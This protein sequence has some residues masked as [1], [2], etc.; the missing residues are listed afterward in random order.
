MLK[1]K[2]VLFVDD[3]VSVLST[4]KRMF[5]NEEYEVLTASSGT[6]GLEILAQ[7]EVDLV[8]SDQRMP[9][10]TGAEFLQQVSHKH[11]NTIRMI[12][13]GY[14]DIDAV[15][16][17]VNKGNISRFLT[18]PWDKDNL[19]QI[20]HHWLS[21]VLY[22]A[23]AQCGNKKRCQQLQHVIFEQEEEIKLL[24]LNL[25]KQD[26]LSQITHDNSSLGGAVT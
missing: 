19:K 25:L 21:I 6:E 26:M 3:E 20:I 24:K 9:R 13:S 7:V 22:E 15:I 23:T 17:A 11:P 4:L 16:D 18:K 5:R 10:M 2:T 14:A 1:N 12:M 8:V